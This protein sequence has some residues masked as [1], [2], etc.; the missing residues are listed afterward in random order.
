M[1]ELRVG[2]RIVDQYVEPAELLTDLFKDSLD[3]LQLTNMTGHR[4]RLA[5]SCDD[6]VRDGLAAFDLARS[7]E[8]TSELQSL[9]RISY[10]VFCF[11]QKKTTIKRCIHS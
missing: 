9:M 5:A 6:S 8:H 1:A 3:L 2:S 11:K 10:D 7:E 4:S